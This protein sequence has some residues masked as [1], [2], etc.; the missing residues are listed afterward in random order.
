MMRALRRVIEILLIEDNPGDA[1]LVRE[2]MSDSRVVTRV[3][4]VE[5]G[6]A[7][8]AFLRR[9]GDYAKA[10][11]PDLIVLDLNLPKLDGRQVLRAI[12]LDPELKQIPVVVLSASALHEDMMGCYRGGASAY[13]TKPSELDAFIAVVRSFDRFWLEIAVLPAT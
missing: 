3:H 6:E 12:K 1:R 8:L 5:D 10:P 2:V 11:R 4:H 7:A 13:V 9:D